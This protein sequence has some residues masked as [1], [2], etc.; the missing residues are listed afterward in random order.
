[1][2]C[3][4]CSEETVP[5]W[6]HYR[7]TTQID[8]LTGEAEIALPFRR[9][10][11]R[12]LSGWRDAEDFFFDLA[13]SDD[14]DDGGLSAGTVPVD[15]PLLRAARCG[16]C[17]QEL[18]LAPTGARLTATVHMPLPDPHPAPRFDVDLPAVGCSHCGARP[19]P[20]SKHLQHTAADL[21]AWLFQFIAA[22]MP[23][24]S[25]TTIEPREPTTPGY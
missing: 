17:G 25:A 13:L 7:A 9:C 8:G 11:A 10:P 16:Q 12:H 4:E 23:P 5:V 15:K 19:E 1:M 14:L 3:L 6:A 20:A 18:E 24:E 2:K 21:S 22:A